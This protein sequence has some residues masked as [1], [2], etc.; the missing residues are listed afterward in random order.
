M[1][2]GAKLRGNRLA[3]V[4]FKK[5]V[6]VSRE[7]REAPTNQRKQRPDWPDMALT[8]PLKALPK[9]WQVLFLRKMR[10]LEKVVRNFLRPVHFLHPATSAK[11]NPL[12]ATKLGD[13]PDTIN[14]NT[15]SVLH[16]R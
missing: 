16:S 2:V 4:R 9:A 14:C 1:A 11:A 12:D 6:S 8:G 15:P 10:V 3:F 5:N 13:R 7:K